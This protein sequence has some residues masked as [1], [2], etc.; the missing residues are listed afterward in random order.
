MINIIRKGNRAVVNGDLK[1]IKIIKKALTVEVEGAEHSPNHYSNG[2]SWDGNKK[3]FNERFGTFGV[4][5]YRYVHKIL[6]KRNIEFISEGFEDRE[7]DWIEFSENFKP[8]E[9]DYQRESIETFLRLGFGIIKVPTRGGKT[10]IAS[11]IIRLLKHKQGEL[12]AIFIVDNVDLFNQAAGDIS[13]VSGIPIEE[14]GKI[15]GEEFRIGKDIT[16]AMIQ[17][18]TRALYP[19]KKKGLKSLTSEQNERKRKFKKFFRSIKFAIVDE[20]QEY[21]STTRINALKSITNHDWFLCLSATPYRD[22]NKIQEL[23]INSICGGVIYDIREKSLVKRKVLAKNRKALLY[24]QHE[25]RPWHSSLSYNEIREKYIYLNKQRNKCLLNVLSVCEKLGL[26]TMAM[27]NSVEHGELISKKSGYEFLSGKD[28][29]D[30][31]GSVKENFIKS[32]GGVLL[33]SDIWKKGITLPTVEVFFNVDGGKESSLIIQRRGRVLGATDTKKKAISFDFIDISDNYLS[34]HSLNRINA[35]EEKIGKKKIDVFEPQSLSK[36][37]FK[38]EIK[39]YLINWFELN[40]PNY[41]D[42]EQN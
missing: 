15:R 10:F 18:V 14:I 5:L 41:S 34:E 24:F 1:A 2:G 22:S 8:K 30:K 31:R 19:T 7:T 23:S 35:Y 38:N 9:R 3:F 21:S 13:K 27:F 6:K 11:E 40:I 25:D 12:N 17:T 28:K 4:G 29:E 39:D 16:I 33:V 37:D 26:K 36:K 20:I 32:S 42:N